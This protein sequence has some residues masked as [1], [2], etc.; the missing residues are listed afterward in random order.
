MNT[1]ER[2]R[3]S[4]LLSKDTKETE[5]EEKDNNK[6]TKNQNITEKENITDTDND[7]NNDEE[8]QK[9]LNKEQKSETDNNSNEQDEEQKDRSTE[10]QK[11]KKDLPER[12]ISFN[13]NK[14]ILPDIN[15]ENSIN[16]LFKFIPF[17]I[18]QKNDEKDEAKKEEEEED[19]QPEVIVLDN[20]DESLKLYQQKMIDLREENNFLKN[21]I[22]EYVSKVAW[23]E[24]HFTIRQENAN[25]QHLQELEHIRKKNEKETKEYN[26]KIKELEDSIDVLQNE[27]TRQTD[28]L[29]DEKDTLTFTTS[30]NWSLEKKISELEDKL[31]I[32]NSETIDLKAQIINI[33][34]QLETKTE[35]YKE[36]EEKYNTLKSESE[37]LSSENEKYKKENVLLSEKIKIYDNISKRSSKSFESRYYQNIYSPTKTNANRSNSEYSFTLYPSANETLS[38]TEPIEIKKDHPSYRMSIT[39]SK[40]SSFIEDTGLNDLIDEISF[41]NESP[42]NKKS[43]KKNLFEYDKS[44]DEI[45]SESKDEDLGNNTATQSQTIL[46]EINLD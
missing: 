41:S 12:K 7:K 14:S 36:L 19:N 39:N 15:I 2:I 42:P 45:L 25:V 22:K 24:E 33:K 5:N 6:D 16:S 35:N 17:N 21:Q 26:D 11:D 31:K 1:L 46:T 4:M 8:E 29:A 27:L 28:L 40:N 34:E 18:P 32:K 9:E 23:L 13:L 43:L 30:A 38:K 37:N 20:T 10:E 3:K 44:I